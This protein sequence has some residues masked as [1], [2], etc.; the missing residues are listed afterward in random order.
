MGPIKGE[1]DASSRSAMKAAKLAAAGKGPAAK[2]TNTP[3]AGDLAA[4]KDEKNKER[5]EKKKRDEEKKA[6]KIADDKK[7]S[8]KTKGKKDDGLDDLLSAGLAK[9]KVKGKK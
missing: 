8:K 9:V 7:A 5:D 4:R 1:T 3:E 2:S 6:K